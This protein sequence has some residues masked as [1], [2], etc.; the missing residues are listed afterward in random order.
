MKMK[1]YIMSNKEV[2]PDAPDAFTCS[3][4]YCRMVDP[5]FTTDGH[6]YERS[7]IEEWLKNKSTSPKTGLP[8]DSKALL[9]NLTLQIQIKEWVDDQRKGRADK[10]WLNALKGNLFGVSTSK[11]AQVVVQQMIQVVTSSN[12]CLLSPDGVKKFERWLNTE[13]LLDKSIRDMLDLLSSQCQSE[14]NTKQ[15]RHRELNTKCVGLDLAKTNVLKKENK[16]KKE[17]TKTQKKAVAAEKKVPVAEKRLRDAQDNLDKVNQAVVDTKKENLK[18]ELNLAKHKIHV[19]DVSKLCSEYLN[20]RENIERQLESVNATENEGGGSSSSS[21]SSSSVP[22][23]SKRGRSSS[24][25]SSSSSS[26]RGSKR[27]KKEKDGVMETHPGQW[28]YEE[29]MAFHSGLDFK[30]RDDERGRLMVE[31]SASSGFPM[32]VACCHL[33]G[34]NGLKEDEKKAFDMCVKIEKE[35]NG[36]H[37]AQEMLGSCYYYG[38]GVGKD[39][40]KRFEYQSLSS[41]QGNSLA[42]NNLG[43][44]YGKGLGTDVNLS[45]AFMWY[46]KSANLG[47]CV[48][49][50]NVG[51]CY[52]YGRGVTKD[53]NKAREWYT[54]AAAQ[55][56]T[57]SQR[58]LDE[59]N[60]Q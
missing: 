41:E 25:T 53:V 36:Y 2:L 58:R 22:T 42:M 43:V 46:E 29:G 39:V 8:L 11:E 32:A 10:V 17:V 1:S 24:A 55:G 30:K 14:I 47:Y 23:G 20:E 49:M 56:C 16:L 28:L 48:S 51:N 12:F 57:A 5:V 37:W 34:M 52:R 60:A 6:S 40:K 4:T 19:Y 59:L 21:S 31:A 26:T 38:K 15:E 35:T 7:A 44:C 50:A 54:K 33:H 9:P 3:I 27:A 13:E 18:A 45:K